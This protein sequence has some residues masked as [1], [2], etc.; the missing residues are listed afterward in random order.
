MIILQVA[1]MITL[2]RARDT[3]SWTEVVNIAMATNTKAIQE[4][5]FLQQGQLTNSI[6]VA[7]CLS[8]GYFV[9]KLRRRAA[10]HPCTLSDR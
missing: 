9:V 3:A 5:Q 10:V 4:I 8:R 7:I 2:Q 1:D 6:V